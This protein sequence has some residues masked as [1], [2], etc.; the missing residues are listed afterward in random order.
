MNLPSPLHTLSL[1]LR[2]LFDAACMYVCKPVCMYVCMMIRIHTARPRVHARTFTLHTANERTYIH[3]FAVYICIIIHTYIH[4]YM[5]TYSAVCIY[6]L[7][8]AV[9][10]VNA[11]MYDDTYTHCKASCTCICIYITYSK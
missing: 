5:H 1:I 8:F 3:N 7:S 4:A 6:V 9:C 11:S 2:N 10:N